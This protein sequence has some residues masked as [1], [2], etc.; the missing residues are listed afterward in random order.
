MT[1]IIQP[2]HPRNR[3]TLSSNGTG[4]CCRSYGHLAP[5][6]PRSIPLA[7]LPYCTPL[8]STPSITSTENFEPYAIRHPRVSRKASTQAAADQAAHDVLV[9]LYP[10][11]AAALDSELQQDLEQ[12]PYG[13]DKTEGIEEGKDVAAAILAL[14]SNDGSAVTLPPFVPNSRPGSYQ[15]TPPKLCACGLHPVAPSHSLCT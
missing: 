2:P 7:I 4:P 14:R 8:S 6:R 15:L 12:I 9:S 10:A 1:T 11:F 3:S 5:N 13:R